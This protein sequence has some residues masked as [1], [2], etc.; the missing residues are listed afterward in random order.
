M[1]ILTRRLGRVALATAAVGAALS[2]A[3]S[4]AHSGP[5]VEGF[6]LDTPTITLGQAYQLTITCLAPHDLITVL[7]EGQTGQSFVN[8]GVPLVLNPGPSNQV[9]YPTQPGE[10]DVTVKCI[11]QSNQ[12]NV[13]TFGPVTLTIEQPP[14]TTPETTSGDS[15]PGTGG[16]SGG[17]STLIGAGA[18]LLA[19]LAVVAVAYRRSPTV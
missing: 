1:S 13:S 11:Q 2:L 7:V 16:S 19:G 8:F 15:L 9:I 3:P 17:E 4:P 14:A 5:P 6:T 12:Q 10:Y 18:L